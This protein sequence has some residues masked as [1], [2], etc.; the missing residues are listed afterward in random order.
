MKLLFCLVNANNWFGNTLWANTVG[1]LNRSLYLYT[2]DIYLMF[3][4]IFL[5]QKVNIRKTGIQHH[6]NIDFTLVNC[7][8]THLLGVTSN[9]LSQ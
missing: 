4:L 8:K 5:E 2:T 7:N 6:I 1:K 3:T 9:F